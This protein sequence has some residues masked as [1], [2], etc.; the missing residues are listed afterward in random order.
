MGA[1]VAG[2]VIVVVFAGM[3]IAFAVVRVVDVVVVNASSS[4]SKNYKIFVRKEG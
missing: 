1:D 4:G 3:D 2:M